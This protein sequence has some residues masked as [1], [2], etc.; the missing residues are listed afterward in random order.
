MDWSMIFGWTSAVGL[1]IFFFGL[2]FL[3]WGIS[4]LNGIYYDKGAR[5]QKK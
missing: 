5:R 4:Y 2:G 3:W 1:G